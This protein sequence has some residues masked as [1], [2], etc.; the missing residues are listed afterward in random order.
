MHEPDFAGAVA[1]EQA[2]PHTTLVPIPEPLPTVNRP[3]IV[4][5]LKAAKSLLWDGRTESYSDEAYIC[6]AA[7]CACGENDRLVTEI[8]TA[9]EARLGGF[10][11][12]AF[13][14]WLLSQHR[15]ASDYDTEQDHANGVI[16]SLSLQAA[17]H[18]WLDQ[19]ITE[20]GGTP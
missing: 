15:I 3:D 18:R 7:A 9:V 8:A 13:D 11:G 17:R 5:V 20:F 1:P 14:S 2:T 16:G 10:H 12:I 6:Y 4:E 19:L